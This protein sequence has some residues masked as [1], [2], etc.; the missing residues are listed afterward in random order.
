MKKAFTLIELIFV[1]VIIGLLAAVAVPKFINLKEHAEINSV[2]KTTLDA[3][4]E[5][6]NAAAN[7][8]ELDD[9]NSFNIGD[10]IRLT[11]KG[12]QCDNGRDWCYYK[13]PVSTN[14]IAKITLYPDKHIV[15]YAISC[16]YITNKTEKEMCYK[17]LNFPSHALWLEKNLTY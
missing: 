2:I 16:Y 17:I 9:N 6:V 15:S 12:W 10:L 1:I 5:A 7:K 11:G 4:H 14:T 13:E 8:Y 3:A